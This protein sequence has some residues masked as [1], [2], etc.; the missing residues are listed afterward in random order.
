MPP[1]SYIITAIVLC[2]LVIASFPVTMGFS[3]IIWYWL[4]EAAACLLVIFGAFRIVACLNAPM[5]IAFAWAAPAVLWAATR[6]YDLFS[7]K[8]HGLSVA[9]DVATFFALL[10]AAVAA[11]KFTEINAKPHWAISIG[12]GTLAMPAV[13]F[14]FGWITEAAGWSAPVAGLSLYLI[15]TIAVAVSLV[16]YGAFIGATVLISLRYHIE[17]WISVTISLVAIYLL[18]GALRTMF[19]PQRPTDVGWWLQPI[20]VLVGAAAV[21]RLGTV[22]RARTSQQASS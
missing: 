7:F 4:F 11:L 21:W 18:C 3:V 19:P 2:A 1:L 14:A 9:S 10:A 6:L 22:L 20:V 13:P 17:R 8:P 16:Q 5:W 15:Q 12:Y